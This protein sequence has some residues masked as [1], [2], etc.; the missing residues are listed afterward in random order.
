MLLFLILL[1]SDLNTDKDS[2]ITREKTISS[3]SLIDF[4]SGAPDNGKVYDYQTNFSVKCRFE[5]S[6]LTQLK[7]TLYDSSGNIVKSNSIVMNYPSGGNASIDG[8]WRTHSYTDEGEHNFYVPYGFNSY[9]DYLVVGGGGGG[10]YAYNYCGGGGGGGGFL[11]GEKSPFQGYTTVQVGNGG[12]GS[13]SVSKAGN[14]G[15]TSS[16]GSIKALG[17]GGGGSGRIT[18]NPNKG[19]AP[20]QGASGGGG[21]AQVL[22]L[23]FNGAS[24]T[25]NQGNKGGNGIGH[26]TTESLQSGGGGGGAGS[27]GASGSGSSGGKGGNGKP[28]LGKYYSAGGGGSKRFG[29][30]G[31]GGSGVGGN[32]GGNSQG[33]DAFPN[34]GSGG[35]GGGGSNFKGGNG[36]SG[37][38]IIR[39]NSSI[40]EE[41]SDSYNNLNPG[42][43]T[44]ALTAST[45]ET[46]SPTITRVFQIRFN[47]LNPLTQK[48]LINSYMF[49][50]LFFFST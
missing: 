13:V 35:G 36:A 37:I 27:P 34:S 20:T 18:G 3:I 9:L 42:T 40:A 47:S 26:D 5:G 45:L 11:S 30:G 31:V 50:I 39:Y 6:F 16:F 4:V 41:L 21:G 10:G 22:L 23:V 48:R 29:V 28:Y 24:G 7:M 8:I 19:T 14:S 44:L 17:G 12:L 1:S 2:E 49:I 32:G 38:V 33:T 43:Y 46:T 15:G 25:T